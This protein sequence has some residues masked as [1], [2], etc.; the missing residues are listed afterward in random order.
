MG[1]M[2]GGAVPAAAAWQALPSRICLSS[3]APK[4]ESSY[5]AFKHVRDSDS[6]TAHATAIQTMQQHVLGIIQP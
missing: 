5:K 1:Q 2:Q 4:M 3:G 6:C